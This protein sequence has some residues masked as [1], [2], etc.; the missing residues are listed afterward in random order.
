MK[1]ILLVTAIFLFTFSTNVFS[2]PPSN[3][4][5][6]N[7]TL[8]SVDL[9]WVDNGC[10]NF[11]TLQ[12]RELGSNTWLLESTTATS[13]YPLISLTGGTDY[14]WRVKCTGQGWFGITIAQFATLLSGCTDV[15][16]CNYD[17][18][19]SIDDGSCILP[20]GCTD[21]TAC[22]YDPLALCDDGSCLL[23]YGCTDVT[24]INF[25]NSATCDDGS[26]SFSLP[27]S[28][29]LAS[30]ITNT[31]VDLIWTDNGCPNLVTLQYRELGSSSWTLASTMAISPFSLS[32]LNVS[33]TYEWRAK[34]TGDGWAGSSV[35][36]FITLSAGCTDSLACNYDA[37]A[38]SDD[39]S[40]DFPDGCTDILACNYDSLATCDDGS[41]L[42]ILGCIDIS[43]FNYSSFA[44]CDDG[45]CIYPTFGCTNINACNYDS[46]ANINDGSCSLP[47][48]C[49]DSLAI[50]YDILATCDDGSCVFPILGC[51]DILA[52]NFNPSANSDDG[53]CVL[54]DGCTFPLADNYDPAALC[55][56]GSCTF[57]T[58]AISNAIISQP[59]RC[60]GD[61]LTDSMQVD[62]SQTTPATTYKC[63]VG[64]YAGNIA[65]PNP[66]VS[67]F[68]SYLSSQQT[69]ATQLNFN[70]FNANTN[71]FVRIV[72]SVTY[73]ST[74]AFGNGASTDGI[75]DQ[76]GPINF[77]QPDSLVVS[78]ASISTNLCFNDC[79]A[80]E[81]IIISGGTQPYNYTLNTN[82]NVVIGANDTQFTL[83]SLC[84]GTYSIV[85]SDLNNCVSD[86]SP[87]FFNIN[88][89]S[90]I[91]P[92][93]NEFLF[94]ASG[95]NISCY[96]ANDGAIIDLDSTTG[97]TPPYL[98][99]ANNISGPYF[100]VVENLSPGNQTIFYQDINGCI[101]S[102]AYTILEPDSLDMT[103]VSVTTP[104]C[105]D[106]PSGK[107]QINVNGGS[108][109]EV[110]SVDPLANSFPYTSSPLTALFG[111]S[112]Y[113]VTVQDQN[114]CQDTIQVYMSEPSAVQID[115]TSSDYNGFGISCHGLN[116]G[117]INA[118]G[119]GGTGPCDYSIDG[120][121]F[122]PFPGFFPNLIAGTY[123]VTA[124]DQN[125]CTKDTVVILTEPGVFSINPVVSS[126]Y[127]GADISCYGLSDGEITSSDSN[128]V[129][130]ILYEFNNSGNLNYDSTWNSLDSGLY[131]IFAE[132]ENGCQITD[133][134]IISD[135][136]ELIATIA[137]ISDE[138]C[139]YSDGSIEVIVNGGTGTTSFLWSNGQ[140]TSTA[141]SLFSGNYSCIV[142]DVNG[143][144][145]TLSESIIND[146]PFDI[147]VSTTSTCLGLSSGTATVNVS[148]NGSYVLT[149][150]TYLWD[151]PLLQ[152]TQTANNLSLG[153]YNIAVNDLN[154]TLNTQVLIDTS[155][156]TVNID[157]IEKIQISCHDANDGELIIHAEGGVGPYSFS[158]N[159]GIS[160]PDSV[161]NNLI[162]ATYLVT[163]E[164]F[165]GCTYSESVDII[166][167]EEILVGSII[168][169]PISCFNECDASIQSIQATGGTP[170]NSGS[171]YL[172]SVNGGLPHP[173]MSYF[174]NYCADTYTVQVRDVNNCLS[175]TFLIISEPDELNVD[176]TTSEWN[177]YQVKCNGENSGYADLSAIGGTLP[178][179]G[180]YTFNGTIT[181]F[182]TSQTVSGLS[183]G[184]YNFE[185]ADN[186][187]CTYSEVISYNE[188]DPIMHNFIPNHVSCSGWSNASLID[189]VY[190]GVGSSS[191][192]I[193]S[194]NTGETTYSLNGIP[195]GLYTITVLDENNCSST[196]SYTI[197]DNNALSVIANVTNVSCFDICDGEISA[198]VSGGLPS[199]DSN[200]NPIYDFLWND[201]L[202]QTTQTAIGLCVDNISNISTY[203]CVITDQQGC[204]VNLT[205]NIT[206]PT[207]IEVTASLISEI[208]CFNGSNGK[209]DANG[210]G[211]TL[212]Y[213][214]MWSNNAP[215]FSTNSD[216]NNI[217]SGTYIVTVMDDKGCTGSDFITINQPTEL[218]LSVTDEPVS[219]FS[220]DD[221]SISATANNG[222]PFL[223][224]PPQYLYTI[225]DE[226]GS[227]VYSE[228]TPVGLAENLSP[229]IYTVTAEDGNG[230][231]IE[232]GTI[233][234]SEP[235]DSLSI[236]FN[237][238][239][240]SCFQNNGSA[241]VI[242]NGGTPNT[243]GPPY[244][245]NW[246]NGNSTLNNNNLEA[247]YYPVTIIDSRGCMVTDS[248]FV[249]GTHNVF[250]D[251][252][253]ELT[254]NICLG[255]SIYIEVNE[256]EFNTYLWEDDNSSIDR[257][258]YPT[259][260]ENIY[261]LNITDPS[262]SDTYQV[263][264][265]VFVDFIDAMPMSSPGIESGSYPVVLEGDNLTL[266][267]DNNNCS[268]YT[269]TWTDSTITNNSGIIIVEDLQKS[270]WYFLDVENAQGCL[271]Y[272][273]IYVVVGVQAY[274]AITPNNDGYNDT[275]TP[276]DIE[277]YEDALV[278]VFNRWG[279]LVFESKG[280]IDYIAWDGTND[281]KEL[282][283]GTYY[284]IIDLNSGDEPQTGPITIIR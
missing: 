127:F 227:I 39:G 186:N 250:S 118:F 65:T 200:G 257:W 278:Q 21:V 22:N 204:S 106:S 105:F 136:Q 11:V 1:K 41:C 97:G 77:S 88:D 241:I 75:I 280:G 91:V 17:P 275:W 201:T 194:W 265:N 90:P 157:D 54:P 140:N 281:G 112:N 7:I 219:C 258:I 249:K 261:T 264:V 234:V 176:I 137:V 10:S 44:N 116:D 167:P 237:T 32:L 111:D 235:G 19:A 181:N 185:L 142:S 139:N 174:I 192:Y 132:D 53:S 182:N 245:Y 131:Q 68:L 236:S 283:V 224:I 51:T 213:Q 193:Y 80:Q 4:T 217:S 252:L 92:I 98:F 262:C 115:V 95:Y 124:R 50:N 56:D 173:N 86:P 64:S 15:A 270:D 271:G 263:Y 158:I 113:V 84:E 162:E 177:N 168:T 59:I 154:C 254:F 96:G 171:P 208:S 251:S 40:C 129:G 148:A 226:N 212:P 149:G 238:V 133:S 272:D 221:G 195:T 114:F 47:N 61:F 33:T 228:T 207:Q 191:S 110:Y 26:C 46:T 5:A 119:F 170:F 190:G 242:V 28:N 74:H 165:S 147:N 36:Q 117:E 267:S 161:F 79:L 199:F 178:Y 196:A 159:S 240:A 189:S 166:N 210:N 211:G 57:S 89:P 268:N 18:L 69:N 63:L 209:L 259:N 94:G 269:W 48:G 248:A 55:N 220:F 108:G 141:D 284:Y 109:L 163:V 172:Y 156:V 31:T 247:G 14:Q 99:S 146:V 100:S 9:G 243:T 180:N 244:Q 104:D 123:T 93:G 102:L 67:F 218:L 197:N 282:A 222:T 134:V 151:D 274:D 70:G 128:G 206:Q 135:P 83:D 45:S 276:L 145:V 16:A 198:N 164:D 202:F 225:N 155:A 232:S 266:F 76:F 214:F 130:L 6:S 85:V 30:N 143:C 183:A 20:D 169:N 215:N 239:N 187:G 24:A 203:E 152:Q 205:A 38:T 34:C 126:D 255:D 256:T 60:Y 2:Q 29:L 216:N 233:Y 23:N 273:S 8:T 230:C 184:I 3:L 150:P 43:A 12:Y 160:S 223:G 49:T 175:S 27:P 125:L 101:D 58:L 82:P 188:P 260:Y 78:A 253:S 42:D 13:P 179:S 122:I 66:G 25:D 103:L 73:Y 246:F 62:I 229:G 138:Y 52:C 279:G 87:L 107:I 72:D 120:V 231:T 153:T 35:E 144:N 71:Y 121:N 277:S 81:Q 37:L